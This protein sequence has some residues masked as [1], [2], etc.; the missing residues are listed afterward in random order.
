MPRIASC[1]ACALRHD[2]ASAGGFG[3]KS[4]S[5]R[6]AR[7]T[8]AHR[9]IILAA[10][11]GKQSWPVI[12]GD[13]KGVRVSPVRIVLCSD[14]LP[15]WV[16]LTALGYVVGFFAGF[17]LG[18]VV[19][20]NIMVGMG[21]GAV[22][23]AFQ[24]LL[25]RRYIRQSALWIVASAAGLFVGLGLYGI[26]N[27]V[28]GYPFDLVWP[29]G[30]IGWALA[31]LSGGLIA[32]LMQRSVLRRYVGRSTLWVLISAIGWTASV[33]GLSIPGTVMRRSRFAVVASAGVAG[34]ILGVISG[35]A[36]L[37]LFRRPHGQS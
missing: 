2:I 37:Q 9:A 8:A 34:I 11:R 25:L 22:T 28:W 20:G 29:R 31:F 14:F 13:V 4:A 19:L 3:Q 12:S 15:L 32:G 24:W 35:F 33:I 36:L 5:G 30:V 6:Y 18:Y 26:A 17:V 1:A 10:S 23:G 21:I 7:L 27:I 16:L